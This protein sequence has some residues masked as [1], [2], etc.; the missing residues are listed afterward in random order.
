VSVA[1]AIQCSR[2]ARAQPFSGIS[3]SQLTFY[4]NFALNLSAGKLENF[5]WFD[6]M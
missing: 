4:R 3:I 1:E 2:A 6:M 5:A